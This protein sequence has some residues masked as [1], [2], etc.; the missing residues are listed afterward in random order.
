[1]PVVVDISVPDIG[2]IIQSYDVIRV[3][4]TSDLV[5]GPYIE[6]T[7]AAAS[8]A[9]LTGSA[10]S[11]SFFVS[12]LTLQVSVDGG[13]AVTTTFTGSNPIAIATIV[14]Q[15]NTALG[16]SIAS[17]ASNAIRL[18]S[19]TVGTG[20]RIQVLSGTSLSIL[21]FTASQ[22]D[23]GEDIYIPLVANQT[24]YEYT[25]LAANSSHHHRY[26]FFNTTTTSNNLSAY[27][28]PVQGVVASPLASASLV[29]GSVSLVDVS[30]IPVSG[31]L[32][33]FYTLSPDLLV[34]GY[35]VG[36]GD[37][38]TS[39]TTDANGQAE[40]QFVVG[41]QLRVVF[42]GTSFVR[43]FTVPTSN[44]D[45]LTVLSSTDDLFNVQQPQIPAAV[46]RTL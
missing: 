15:L 11:T 35:V 7:A 5:L 28:G 37:R 21:G 12:G 16:A 6:T 26:R 17:N 29:T 46:R 23:F 2:S 3:E 33:E 22:E 44:F 9:V 30:G 40:M 27:Y 8:A 32:I 4:R 1:M 10:T 41:Q 43:Q 38:S 42:A 36:M 34:S 13:T 31:Q 24:S 20:S 39:F 14:T 18:T 19:T 45:L 25:D